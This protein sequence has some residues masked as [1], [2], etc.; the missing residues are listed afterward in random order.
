MKRVA[1]YGRVSTQRQ[2]AEGTSAKDQK[3]RV[4]KICQKE[5]WALYKFY[6]DDGFSGKNMENRPGIQ[7][8]IKDA[9]NDKF[10]VVMFTKLDRVGRNL[11]EVLNF[12]NLIQEKL[13]LQLFCIDDHAVNTEGRLG[14]AMVGMLGMFAEF[15]RDLIRERMKGGRKIKWKEGSV[16][17]GHPPYG[18]KWNKKLKKIEKIPEQIEIYKKI[19]SLYVD[20]N[21]SMLTIAIMLTDEGIPTPSAY[22]NKKRQAKRWNTQSVRKI[23]INPSYKGSAFH[24][25]TEFE[26]ATSEKQYMFPSK[27]KKPEEEW[28]EVKF[29]SVI[30]EERWN[31]IQ[32]RRKHNTIK[33]KKKHKE[34]KEHFMAENVVFCGECG[35]KMKK[36][37]KVD[38]KGEASFFYVCNWKASTSKQLI[39]AGRERCILKYVNAE[40]IDNL[41]FSEVVKSITNP[42]RYAKQWLKDLNLDEI[43][44]KRD[45][46]RKKAKGLERKIKNAYNLITD[47]KNAETR[48]L[49]T[50]EKNKN[51]EELDKVKSALKQTENE[52]NLSHNKIDRYAQFE[53]AYKNGNFRKRSGTY[54]KTQAEFID[55]LHDLPFEEKKRILEAVISPETGGRCE[56]RYQRLIELIDDDVQVSDEVLVKPIMDKEPVVDMNF[57]VDI[58]RVEGLITGID[59]RELL[60]QS[61][62]DMITVE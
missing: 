43:K 62:E 22:K 36:I 58:N 41:I 23:L 24:N 10:D 28:I 15:E 50:D 54:F 27:K 52:Y 9:N 47:E 4:Q 59:N 5:G 38:K 16:F 48:Q 13:N 51:Q 39:S 45:R 14:K 20:Q 33:P 3:D 37:P 31:Q 7:E 19:V 12:W 61:S 30:S 17:I 11:R 40:N 53:Q 6:S 8:L 56:V 44:L 60:D 26:T 49:F 18:Y 42:G 29:P 34:Y 21:Y 35:S 57:D 2:V 46:L 32:L 1:G 25:K 55:F